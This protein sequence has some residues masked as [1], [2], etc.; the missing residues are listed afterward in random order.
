MNAI[1]SATP[2]PAKTIA[3]E[4]QQ[5]LMTDGE[6]GLEQQMAELGLSNDTRR[7]LRD[8]H[9]AEKQLNDAF[10]KAHQGGELGQRVSQVYRKMY[11]AG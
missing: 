4:N 7:F 5:S 9:T 2:M 8:L 11:R 3:D 10:D 6:V 1:M